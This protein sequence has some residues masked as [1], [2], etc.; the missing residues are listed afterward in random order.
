MAIN[1]RNRRAS[2]LLDALVFPNPDGSIVVGDRQQTAELYAFTS[3]STSGGA[4]ALPDSNQTRWVIPFR[5]GPLVIQ[6]TANSFII[7]TQ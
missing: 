3:T 7:T 5:T 4:D 2:A 6:A 1:T